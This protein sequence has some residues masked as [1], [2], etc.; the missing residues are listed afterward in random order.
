MTE[1]GKERWLFFGEGKNG[2]S[3][4]KPWEVSIRVLPRLPQPF[5]RGRISHALP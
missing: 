4:H 2:T 5:P 3:A 1:G